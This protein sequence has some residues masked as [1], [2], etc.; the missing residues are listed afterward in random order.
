MLCE[1]FEHWT[2]SSFRGLWP[3]V[4][5][6]SDIGDFWLDRHHDHLEKKLT[7]LIYTDHARLWPGTQLSDHYTIPS[8]DNRCMF[9]VPAQDTWHSYPATHFDVV[10][11][12][13]QINYWTYPAS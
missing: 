3:R 5:V 4:E 2:R 13:L 10:R 12:A 9:F 6:I 8:R 1:Y 7:A 11:R